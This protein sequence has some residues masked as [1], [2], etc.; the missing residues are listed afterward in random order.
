MTYE[1]K[2]VGKDGIAC[3]Y[4]LVLEIFSILE[5]LRWEKNCGHDSKSVGW[6]ASHPWLAHPR[7]MLKQINGYTQETCLF[8]A[9]LDSWALNVLGQFNQKVNGNCSYGV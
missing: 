4:T 8:I 9:I 3:T 2:V 6:P 7:K 5:I 1:G